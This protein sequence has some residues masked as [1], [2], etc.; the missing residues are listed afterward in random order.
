MG[1]RT[2]SEIGRGSRQSGKAFEREIARMLRERWPDAVVRRA[3]QADRAVRSD[4]FVESGGPAV[5]SKLWWELTRSRDLTMGGVRAKLE[6]AKRDVAGSAQPDRFPVI[7]WR[8]KGSRS[9]MAT[10]EMSFWVSVTGVGVLST[11]RDPRQ[12]SILTTVDLGD[13]LDLL[14]PK[15]VSPP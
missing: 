4:V 15:G 10:V 1:T 14:A 11:N 7:V 6:Q 5:L 9:T 3:S 8:D 2:R 13:L 12:L